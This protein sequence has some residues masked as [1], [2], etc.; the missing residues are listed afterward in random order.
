MSQTQKNSILKLAS[1]IDEIIKQNENLNA[2]LNHL[3]ACL[4]SINDQAQNVNE[5]VIFG[6]IKRMRLDIRN[7]VFKVRNFDLF[8]QTN[9]DSYDINLPLSVQRN[10]LSHQPALSRHL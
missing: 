6:T 5:E 2:H 7:D 9:L 3:S 1:Q 4:R 10:F 8:I